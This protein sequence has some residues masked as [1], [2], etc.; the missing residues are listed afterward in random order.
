MTDSNGGQAV[1]ALVGDG[2]TPG[3][4]TISPTSQDFKT[5][6]TGAKSSAVSFTVTNTGMTAT[7]AISTSVTGTEAADFVIDATSDTCAGKTLDSKATCNLSVV[8]GPATAG[9]RSASLVATDGASTTTAALTG[10][11]VGPAAF[12]ITPAT[13]DFKTVV[14]GTSSAPQKFTVTNSGGVQSDTPQIA[15]S[16]N[17]FPTSA[18]TAT[19]PLGPGATCSFDNHV[20]SRHHQRGIG[21]SDGGR[22]GDADGLG[23]SH[24]HGAG[25]PHAGDARR[26]PGDGLHG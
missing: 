1:S 24:R 9:A 10:T 26:H 5:V 2:A 18:S 8:F 12:T 17:D 4:L 13:F 15:S 16:S 7:K 21:D 22:S 3:T 14:Q 11:A 20:R 25:A 6:T 19:A 23:D